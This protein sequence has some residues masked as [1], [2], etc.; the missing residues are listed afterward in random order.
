MIENSHISFRE[1]RKDDLDSVL[2]IDRLSFPLPWPES[3]YRHDLTNNSTAILWVAEVLSEDQDSKVVGMVDV[4]LIQEEAHIATLAV[5][6]DYRGN[7]IAA[8]L[9][10]KVLFEAYKLGAQRAMLEVRESNL[11]ARTLYED[12]GFVTVSRRR[13]YY[14][15][16]N[17]DALLMNLDNLQVLI[18]ENVEIHKGSKDFFLKKAQ[19]D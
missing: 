1:M 5:H 11:A 12:F 8:D 2:V 3:A 6:P 18:D 15:D 13:R 19:C 10:S 16:N 17:E 14:R 7:G 9:L 4:W